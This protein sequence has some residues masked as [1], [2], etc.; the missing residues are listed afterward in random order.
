MKPLYNG[1]PSGTLTSSYLDVP[2]VATFISINLKP[3]NP[4]RCIFKKNATNSYGFSRFF[5]VLPQRLFCVFCF[6][7]K[8][9][10]VADD[11]P[12]SIYIYIFIYHLYMLPSGGTHMLPTYHLFWAPETT[13]WWFFPTHSKNIF[14]KMDSSSPI[15]GMNI[16]NALSCH[17]PQDPF[18]W[19]NLLARVISTY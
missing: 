4:A 6:P 3:L 11:P 7:Q 2:A 1:G 18:S 16:K 10:S 14:V 12:G 15:F 13:S 17:H 5:R 19:K 9:G 8:A